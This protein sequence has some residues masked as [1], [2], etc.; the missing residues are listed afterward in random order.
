VEFDQLLA[1]HWRRTREKASE[2]EVVLFVQDTTELDFTVHG[3]TRGLGQ[4]GNGGG[5][6]FKLHNVMALDPSGEGE[7]LGQAYNYLW[8]RQSAPKGESRRQSRARWRESLVWS[9]AIE[10]VGSGGDSSRWIHVGDRGADVFET[11]AACEA[12]QVGYVIRMT[13]DR[14]IRTGHE[15]GGADSHLLG[16]A[17]GLPSQATYELTIRSRPKRC[18]RTA[19]MAL[20]WAPVTVQTPWRTRSGQTE[21][22][23]GWVVRAWEIDPPKGEKAIEWV[24]LTSEPV[25]TER[26]AKQVVDWYSL[27][28]LIEEYHKCLKTGCRV[29]SSQLKE[30][31]RLRPLIALALVVATELLELKLAARRRPEEPATDRLS[32]DHVEMLIA[33]RDLPSEPLTV[34]AFWREVAKLGGFLGRRSDGEPGWQTI[35]RGW[36][37]LDLMV[38]GARIA[39]KTRARC[40]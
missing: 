34:G 7:M 37:R 16:Y 28:W 2:R 20:S 11:F 27:R 1:P 23:R 10:A 12:Q 13:Y 21:P 9:E 3:S 18:G 26:V 38:V 39:Q 15:P 22:V 30:A 36:T 8:N 14:R 33:C 40:G 6:G 5:R 25:T 17:R 24:L 35:W 29:E 19:Q 32:R 4:I 31:Q